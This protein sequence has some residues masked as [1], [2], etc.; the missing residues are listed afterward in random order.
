MKTPLVRIY[1]DGSA[2]YRTGYGAWA[3]IA[4]LADGTEVNRCQ[5]YERTTN[6]QMELMAVLEAIDFICNLPEIDPVTYQIISDSEYVVNGIN[7]W[8]FAWKLKNW[9]NVKNLPLWLAIDT[10]MSTVAARKIALS[11]TWVK[12]HNGDEYN[13]KCDKL[14]H[15]AFKK[16]SEE[17]EKEAAKP[18]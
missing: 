5:S 18:T 2:H 12:G 1:T 11:V 3:F 17:K 10:A 8:R 13:E 9:K 15:G 16:L 4:I 7:T 14:A 6:N